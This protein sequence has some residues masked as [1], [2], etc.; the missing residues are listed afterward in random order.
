[1]NLTFG[2]A[3][4]IASGTLSLYKFGDTHQKLARRNG[5]DEGN[6]RWT[7]RK[8]EPLVSEYLRVLKGYCN[9]YSEKPK[10]GKSRKPE[11]LRNYF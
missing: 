10:L 8:E 4:D 11:I 6:P 5:S 1:M 7:S 2:I 9:A 3:A